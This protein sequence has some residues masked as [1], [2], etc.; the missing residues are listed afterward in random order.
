MTMTQTLETRS[1]QRA[2]K[3]IR[4]I[5]VSRVVLPPWQFSTFPWDEVCNVNNS[6]KVRKIELKIYNSNKIN[7]LK[8]GSTACYYITYRPVYNNLVST[9]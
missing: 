4:L 1:G 2:I 3:Q 7:N 5:A 8:T 6:T 9:V